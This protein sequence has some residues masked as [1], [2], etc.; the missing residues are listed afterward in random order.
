[1][2]SSNSAPR[3]GPRHTSHWIR[4]S[5]FRRHFYFRTRPTR[6]KHAETRGPLAFHFGIARKPRVYLFS[7]ASPRV[8]RNVT[9]AAFTYRRI[10]RPHCFRRDGGGAEGE[11]KRANIEGERPRRKETC[12]HQRLGAQCYR[13]QEWPVP[14]ISRRCFFVFAGSI[15]VTV[16]YRIRR[17]AR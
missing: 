6:R 7:V 14:P 9:R 10:N 2:R 1:M 17:R 11:E 16:L 5:S 13:P 12:Q 8:C 4:K 3:I 15:V